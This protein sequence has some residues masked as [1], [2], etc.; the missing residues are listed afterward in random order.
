M[1]GDD[2]H[3]WLIV[4]RPWTLTIR[5]SADDRCSFSSRMKGLVA[6]EGAVL[7][8]IFVLCTWLSSE[9]GRVTRRWSAEDIFERMERKFFMGECL[10]NCSAYDDKSR[11]KNV[12]IRV[13][14]IGNDEIDDR[15]RFATNMRFISSS[16]YRFRRK[17]SLMVTRYCLQWVESIS[18]TKPS[19][20]FGSMISM[21]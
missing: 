7:I 1:E 9:K 3:C 16:V 5:L 6:V 12:S 10:S 15:S 14:N 8:L 13:S 20:F 2:W 18:R 19:P 21:R 11:D 17:V 4:K